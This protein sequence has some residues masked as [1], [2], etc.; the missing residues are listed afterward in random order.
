[1]ELT[2]LYVI[3]DRIA[4]HKEIPAGSPSP[5]QRLE[6]LRL[7][8]ADQPIVEVSDIE[9]RREGKSY[10][11]ETVEQ[12]REEYPEDE[13]ILFMGTDMF[14]T[15]YQWRF[16]E[17]ILAQA[18][19]GVFYRGEKQEKEQIARQKEAIEAMG[20]RVYL[21]ENPVTEISSTQIRRLM[22]MGCA[23][24]YLPE[25]V[26]SY[27]RQHD[28]YG[29]NNCYKN[30]PEEELE[31]VVCSLLDP[32]R[33]AHVL[34]CRDTAYE[35]AGL[36]GADKTD[37]VR[38]ALLHDVT[39]AL[40][41]PLQLQLCRSYDIPLN[42]FHEKNPK[43][44]HAFTGSVIAKEVFGENKQV[45][46]AIC[47]HTTGKPGMSTLDKI[48]YVADYIEPNRDF[49]GVQK[50]RALAYSNL[51]EALKLGLTMTVDMLKSQGREVSVES[52]QTLAWLKN[53][54]KI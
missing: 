31:Q 8:L 45:A 54:R 47:S 48:I 21:V 9:L 42:A 16:P 20:A 38:A 5:Q 7:A 25:G 40:D 23:G 36:W 39:K 24:A 15:F 27:I 6:M 37:A 1:L 2:K 51:D 10:T 46:D 18:S 50:L 52:E 35:L 13:L 26:E 17:R 4:P 34:G 19:I 12:L 53:E 32:K 49:P 43:T 41:G 30:L 44:L 29:T 33:V 14:L 28:L 11:Y 22:I 3:P